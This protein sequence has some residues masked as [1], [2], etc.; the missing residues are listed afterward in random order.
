MARDAISAAALRGARCARRGDAKEKRSAARAALDDE[1][2]T[3]LDDEHGNARATRRA[4]I[5]LCSAPGLGRGGRA[6]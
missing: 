6:C 3:A 1:H 5:D 2:G 4:H